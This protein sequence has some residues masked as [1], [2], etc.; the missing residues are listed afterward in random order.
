MFPL[1]LWAQKKKLVLIRQADLL[2]SEVWGDTTVNILVGRVILEH[3]GALMYCDSAYRYEEINSFDAF[4]NIHIH[5]RDSLDLYSDVLFYDGNTKLAE[6]HYN[7]R[8]VDKTTTLFTEHLFYDRVIKRAHYPDSGRIVDKDNVLT[9][10]NGYYFTEPRIFQF[11]HQVKLKNPDYVLTG[12]SLD[13]SAGS[14]TAFVKGPTEIVGKE[15]YIYTE[16][17]WYDTRTETASLK[18]KVFIRNKDRTLTADSVFYRDKPGFARAFRKITAHDTTRR[19]ILKGDFAEYNDSLG[20]VF[21]TQNALALY[22]EKNKPEDTLYL[23][24]DTLHLT[25]DTA[26]E[27]RWFY[28]WKHVK[29]LETTYRACAILWS[30]IIPIL[31]SL[32]MGNQPCGEIP[33]NSHPTVSGSGLL[34]QRPDSM[35]MFNS[36]FIIQLDDSLNFNQMR[37]RDM[38]A[39]FK[40]GDLRKVVITGNAETI[41]YLR[42]DDGNLIG[43]NNTAASNMYM[44]IE[45]MR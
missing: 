4:G 43:I 22:Y 3:D 25:F 42:E 39:Y 18:T 19:V 40:E 30:I 44:W 26:R 21:V 5:V 37:G 1:G 20:Y 6:M 38:K 10:R 12:D 31:F 14:K 17:G 16:D 7:V 32:C 23:H 36:A 41:Y 34:N 2:R 33:F 11:R 24:A 27:A 45:K 13:Y 35:Y 28:A 9:S 29:F 8:L 15:K